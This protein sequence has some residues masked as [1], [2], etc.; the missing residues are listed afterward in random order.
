VIHP[1]AGTGC[2]GQRPDF[3]LPDPRGV[4]LRAPIG[5]NRTTLSGPQSASSPH[6]YDNGVE[7]VVAL[8][9]DGILSAASRRSWATK[10]ES[11]VRRA[12]LT[13]FQCEPIPRAAVRLVSQPMGHVKSGQ[14]PVSRKVLKSTGR[15][16][17]RGG[18]LCV[19]PSYSRRLLGDVATEFSPWEC[20][21]TLV[22]QM[23]VLSSRA[24]VFAVTGWKPRE[25]LAAPVAETRDVETC[26]SGTRRREPSEPL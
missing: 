1:P 11:V 4:P 25:S 2:G 14:G 5:S 12:L 13:R 26:C 15:L 9:A 17:R 8:F 10:C 7:N 18:F 3:D 20:G 16:A 23:A 21:H 24:A 22:K 19:P 6:R